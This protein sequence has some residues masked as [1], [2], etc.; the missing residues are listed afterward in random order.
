MYSNV[1]IKRKCRQKLLGIINVT[2]SS[3]LP[4]STVLLKKE[5]INFFFKLLNTEKY[6]GCQKLYMLSNSYNRIS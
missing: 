5:K 2:I 3:R 1:L 6:N 4:A